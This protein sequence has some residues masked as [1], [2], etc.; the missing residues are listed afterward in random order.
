MSEWIM[1]PM[2]CAAAVVFDDNILMIVVLVGLLIG[3][4]VIRAIIKWK[5]KIPLK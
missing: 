2:E 5:A 1:A 3:I 4:I